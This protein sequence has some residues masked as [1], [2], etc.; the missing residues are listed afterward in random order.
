M[1]FTVEPVGLVREGLKK[2]GKEKKKEEKQAVWFPFEH[3]YARADRN[4]L[5]HWLR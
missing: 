2:R 5:I 1:E 3:K 4:R